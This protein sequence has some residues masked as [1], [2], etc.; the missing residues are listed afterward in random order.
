MRFLFFFCES[1]AAYCTCSVRGAGS[2]KH[3]ACDNRQ[4]EFGSG[5]ESKRRG[6]VDLG[7]QSKDRLERKSEHKMGEL[8]QNSPGRR[9]RPYFL[10]WPQTRGVDAHVG[11]QS[12]DAYA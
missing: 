11:L 1:V 10:L 2:G 4:N 12:P 7:R 6:A 5:P 9:R 3:P 8:S